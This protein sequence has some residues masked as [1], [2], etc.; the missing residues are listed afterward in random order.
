MIYHS[1]WKQIARLE[2]HYC[3]RLYGVSYGS[4]PVETLPSKAEWLL[5]S[6]QMYSEGLRQFA[7]HMVWHLDP[8]PSKILDRRSKAP[9][10]LFIAPEKAYGFQFRLENL[11][12]IDGL[13]GGC[14]LVRKPS[15][16]VQRVCGFWATESP[17][18]SIRIDIPRTDDRDVISRASLSRHRKV[19]FDLSVLEQLIVYSQLKKFTVVL[20]ERFQAQYTFTLRVRWENEGLQAGFDTERCYM[21]SFAKEVSRIGRL[22]ISNGAEKTTPLEQYWA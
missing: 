18:T 16:R 13:D 7:Q 3:G 2:Q 10:N 21:E 9:T 20:S 19:D 17:L 22:L 11:T 14:H 8:L 5:A 4:A 15:M 6:K 1:I 12:F